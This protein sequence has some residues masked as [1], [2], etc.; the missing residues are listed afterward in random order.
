MFTVDFKKAFCNN[1]C[2]ILMLLNPVEWFI[3]AV[4]GLP[5]APCRFQSSYVGSL[6]RRVRDNEGAMDADYLRELA[7][8]NDP[9]AVIRLFESQPSLHNSQSALAEYVKALVKVDRLDASEL[10]RTLQ[11]GEF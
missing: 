2:D 5:G 6:A 11:R 10:L 4:N 8:R 1:K 3:S 7:Q 9:E